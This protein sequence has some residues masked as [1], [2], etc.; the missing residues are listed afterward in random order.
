MQKSTLQNQ[1]S[2]SVGAQSRFTFDLDI[3]PI[4]HVSQVTVILRDQH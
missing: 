4:P 2:Q 1:D 3:C